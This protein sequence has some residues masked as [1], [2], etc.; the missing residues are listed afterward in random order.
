MDHFRVPPPPSFNFTKPEEW[1]KWIK[2]VERF[3]IASGLQLQAEENQFSRDTSKFL[4]QII[5]QSGVRADP[6]KLEAVTDMKEPADVSGVR[7][8]LGM[9]NHLSKYLPHLAEKTQ[10]LR[11]LLRAKN[12]FTWGDKQQ[13]AFDS[14]KKDLSTPSGLVLYS[15][16]AHTADASSYGLGAV[17]L[18]RQEDGQLKPVTYAFRVLTN[19]EQR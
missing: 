13:E 14:I 18:Q 2:G 1:P 4:G 7:R 9:V 15:A 17:L 6:D 11:D 16:K 12:M 19:I 3:R 5:D 8:F 10:P